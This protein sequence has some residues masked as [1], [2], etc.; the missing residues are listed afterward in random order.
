MSAFK[1]ENLRLFGIQRSGTP[2]R[3]T[4]KVAVKHSVRFRKD[5]SGTRVRTLCG[6]ETTIC[7]RQ[8]FTEESVWHR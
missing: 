3:Y 4:K 7:R 1:R 8:V 2:H 6:R 5:C